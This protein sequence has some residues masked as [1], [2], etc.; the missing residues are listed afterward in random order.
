M[1]LLSFIS[2]ALDKT[3]NHF[4]TLEVSKMSRTST[5]S[6]RYDREI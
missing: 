2:I 4:L 1:S 3:T 5:N 6:G